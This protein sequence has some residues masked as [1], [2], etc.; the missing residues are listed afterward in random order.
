MAPN[1]SVLAQRQPPP[2]LEPPAA[3]DEED[4]VPPLLARPPVIP[5]RASTPVTA[6]RPP[7][8]GPHYHERGDGLASLRGLLVHRALEVSGGTPDSLDDGALADL[9]HEQSER[10][11]DE[12]AARALAAEVR[13]MLDRFTGS[14]VAAALAAPGIERWFE[15]PFAWD[16]EG[17]PIH[18]SIDL[19][20]RDASGWHVIDFKS[21]R[22]NGNSAQ[23]TASRYAV[24]IGLYQRAIEAAVGEAASVGLLFLR[25]GELARLEPAEVEA[26]LVEARERVG[27]GVL[28]E[29]VDI[30]FLDEPE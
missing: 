8:G 29:P 14:P 21:D 19:V 9:A 15:L 10:A 28:L 2:V 5:L 3:S 18:G 11:L 7:E 23:E 6:L 4:Y 1:A 25:S 12:A 17:V 22:L 20:Y 16:W 26:A 30:G 24:Q 13:E 27:A